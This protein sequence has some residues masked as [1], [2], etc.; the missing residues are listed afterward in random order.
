MSRPR[1]RG[2]AEH[3]APRDAH[4]EGREDMTTTHPLQVRRWHH[5]QVHYRAA[6]WAWEC[7]CGA[8]G[9]SV[10]VPRT[11]WITLV[12]ALRHADLSIG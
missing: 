12:E 11:W 1:G 5:P 8:A 6:G 2:E 7:R 9:R 3:V 4:G 10:V